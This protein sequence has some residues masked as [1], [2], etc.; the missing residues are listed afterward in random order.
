MIR[1]DA[2]ERSSE[3]GE[4]L[5]LVAPLITDARVQ[6]IVVRPRVGEVRALV[7][8]PSSGLEGVES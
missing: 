6:D 3:T 2:T 7:V 8:H 5:S 4:Q 1:R